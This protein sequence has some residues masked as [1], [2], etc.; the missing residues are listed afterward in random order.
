ML[1]LKCD[2]G[3]E[4]AGQ[5]E[6][7]VIVHIEQFSIDSTKTKVITLANHDGRRTNSCKLRGKTCSDKSHL[8]LV[9]LMIG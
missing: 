9:L 7:N 5:Y 2:G 4:T 1:L 8:V 3:C 6:I